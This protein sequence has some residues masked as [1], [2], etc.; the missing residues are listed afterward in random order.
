MLRHCLAPSLRRQLNELPKSLD[1]TYERVLKE[2]QSTNQGRYAHRLLQCLVVAIRPLRVDEL[3]EVLS[4]DLDAPEGEIPTHHPEW[5]WED[6]EQAVLSACSSLIAVVGDDYSRVVQFSHFSVKEYLTSDRLAASSGDISRYHILPEPA[7]F[8]LAQASLGALL[9]CDDN[10]ANNESHRFNPL[11]LYAAEHWAIHAQVG[12]VS[13]RLKHTM[14][15]LFDLDQPYFLT[16]VGALDN[17]YN[18]FWYTANNCT[19]LYYAALCGFYDLVRHIIAKHPEQVNDCGGNLDC[20]P[21]VAALFRKHFRVAELLVIHDAQVNVWGSPP[22]FHVIRFSDDAPLD[23]VQFLLKHGA[24]VNAMNKYHWTPLHL[25]TEMGYLEVARMLLE[26]GAELDLRNDMGQT[27][28]HL[29]SARMFGEHEGE[30]ERFL[31][32]QLLVERGADVKAQ[33]GDNSSPLHFASYHGQAEIAQLLLDHGA[34]AQAKSIKGR[35]PLHE[36]SPGIHQYNWYPHLKYAPGYRVYHPQKA[37][38]VA[39]LLLEHK[40][41]VNTLDNDHATPLHLASSHGMLEVAQLL[42]ERGATANVENVHGQTPLHLVSQDEGISHETPDLAWLLLELGVSVNAQDKD[43]ATPLHHACS[44]VNFETALV[45]LDNGA[46]PKVQD[47]DGQTPLHRVSDADKEDCP[48]VAQL[49]LARGA[50]VN[51]RTRDQETPLHLG[52][53]NWNI[54]TAQVLLSHDANANAKNI[55]GLTPLQIVSKWSDMCFMPEPYSERLEVVRLSLKSG[56][57]VNVRDKDRA[58]PLH[59]ASSHQGSRNARMLL[60]NGAEVNAVNIHGQ[61]PLH[62]ISRKEFTFFS[63]SEESARLLLERGVDVN[64]RDKDETTP[65]HL[66]CYNGDIGVVEILLNHGAQANAEDIRGQ[67]PLHQV[68]LGNR[69]YR[70]YSIPESQRSYRRVAQQLLECGADVNARNKDHE[71]PL[72]LALRRRLLEMA[73]FLLEHGADV[74]V[75]NSKGRSLLQFASGRKRREIKQLLLEYS[76][77][78]S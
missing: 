21:L 34:N 77:N 43:L 9:S 70:G 44:H 16:W 64:G 14:E 66:A 15:N 26:H 41:D 27:P 25:A 72:H 75:K 24:K 4:H 48:R 59:L 18:S 31:L 54:K 60:D 36:V 61:N 73:Q 29:V 5:R 30:P 35:I 52:L 46:E 23:A 1:E 55:R 17:D 74:I 65:L 67:T 78:Q 57:D 13:S 32:A 22:L 39:L 68:L 62:S 58:T 3:A 50:D 2:I 8:T 51:A 53:H 11:R 20:Y 10:F 42:I 76:A 28:L 6:Q 7:H 19:P 37:F 12:N 56:G 47:A 33:D 40:V 38:N 49:L 71:T 45:L 69:N 63:C